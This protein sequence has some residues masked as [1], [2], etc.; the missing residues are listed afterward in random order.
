[1]NNIEIEGEQG[2]IYGQYLTEHWCRELS[3]D[4]RS[5]RRMLSYFAEHLSITSGQGCVRHGSYVVVLKTLA[6]PLA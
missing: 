6:P 5:N 2:H 3:E 1:M 4:R